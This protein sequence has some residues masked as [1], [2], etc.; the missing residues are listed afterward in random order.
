MI[1]IFPT[2][3]RSVVMDSLVPH[4]IALVIIFL[5]VS[6]FSPS[7]LNILFPMTDLWSFMAFR[8]TNFWLNNI[9]DI[10]MP[11]LLVPWA[12][13]KLV[14]YKKK[15]GQ[16]FFGRIYKYHLSDMRVPYEEYDDLVTFILKN[17]KKLQS[18]LRKEKSHVF[19]RAVPSLT[20]Q[21]QV[22]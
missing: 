21:R 7:P 1:I 17:Y 8:R 20:R 15:E 2:N 11:S 9:D 18:C 14:D 10:G 19:I 12:P 3:I 5:G 22:S 16:L 13:Y 4:T 6:P